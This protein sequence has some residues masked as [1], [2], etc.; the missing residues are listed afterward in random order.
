MIVVITVIVYLVNSFFLGQRTFRNS[1]VTF[2][3]NWG[4]P[5]KKLTMLSILNLQTGILVPI[6]A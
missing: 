6:S 5:L 2:C 1:D 3:K 4:I